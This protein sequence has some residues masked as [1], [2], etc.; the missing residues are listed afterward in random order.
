MQA[1][2]PEVPPGT[3]HLRTCRR[4]PYLKHDSLTSSCS[5]TWWMSHD[6]GRG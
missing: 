3:R 1:S 2:V 6:G 4:K 5:V